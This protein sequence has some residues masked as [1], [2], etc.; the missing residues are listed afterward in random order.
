METVTVPFPVPEPPPLWEDPVAVPEPAL[1]LDPGAVCEEAPLGLLY[2]TA[3]P[4]KVRPDP[5]D[6]P[7]GELQPQ[8]RVA[9]LI[10]TTEITT[11][12]SRLRRRS[13]QP[14]GTAQSY[15]APM[16]RV[17]ANVGSGGR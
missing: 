8:T 17:A 7:S 12:R 3:A 16:G 14:F 11:H 2:T 15:V 10:A 5:A 6:E 1:E 4:D 9:A 13:R